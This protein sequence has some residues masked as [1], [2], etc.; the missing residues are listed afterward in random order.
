MTCDTCGRIYEEPTRFADGLCRICALPHLERAVEEAQRK[1]DTI[2]D[3]LASA[4]GVYNRAMRDFDTARTLV[5][6]IR[7]VM[8]EMK[9]EA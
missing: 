7:D 9:E 4:E 8:R 3:V 2:N 1:V 6:D 5:A